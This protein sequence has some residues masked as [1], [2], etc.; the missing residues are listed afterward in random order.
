MAYAHPIWLLVIHAGSSATRPYSPFVILLPRW[1]STL[2]TSALY[3]S[4]LYLFGI[5]MIYFLPPSFAPFVPALPGSL[6]STRVS[7]VYLPPRRS[8]LCFWRWDAAGVSDT[9]RWISGRTSPLHI[10]T[11]TPILPYVV[12]ASQNHSQ[13]LRAGSEAG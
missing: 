1:G 7:H 8:P 6:I 2:H 10:Q 4:V 3:A 9:V 11:L 13:C 12:W 5:N